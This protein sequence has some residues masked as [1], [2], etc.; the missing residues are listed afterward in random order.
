MTQICADELL[1]FHHLPTFASF[2]DDFLSPPASQF[3][4]RERFL[5]LLVFEA[6]RA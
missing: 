4:F 1:V 2:A 6:G 5:E 3:R